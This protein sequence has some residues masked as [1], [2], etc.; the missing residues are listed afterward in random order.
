MI[1]KCLPDAECVAKKFEDYN[2]KYAFHDIDGTHSLIRDWPPVMSAVLNDVIVNGL[3]SDFDSDENRKRLIDLCGKQSNSE[4]DD[5][6]VESAGLSALTQMEWAI[7]RAA[8]QGTVKVC[9]DREDNSAKIRD[10]YI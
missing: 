1:V 6:C 2:I 4:T 9:F 10:I 8:E 7:R 3:P 5:F